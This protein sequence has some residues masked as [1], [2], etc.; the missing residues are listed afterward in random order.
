MTSNQAIVEVA[1]V[2][3]DTRH[4]IGGNRVA[5]ADTFTNTSPI[6]GSFLGEFARGTATEVD[7]AV[8][9]ARAAFPAWRDLGAKR[10]GEL[11]ENLAKLI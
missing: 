11:L 7:L 4:Y 10:R 2:Q 5:S 1:G 3:I 6:D 8:Q 9:A